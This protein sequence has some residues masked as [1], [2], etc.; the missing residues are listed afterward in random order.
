[1]MM[2]DDNIYI[3]PDNDKYI[4]LLLV[5]SLE[6]NRLL[7]NQDNSI[8]NN[9]VKNIISKLLKMVGLYK[10]TRMIYRSIIKKK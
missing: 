9:K 7:W 10:F 5:Y 4:E 1:M 3:V 2:C 8:R 6:K